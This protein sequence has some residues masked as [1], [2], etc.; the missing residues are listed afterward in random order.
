[1]KLLIIFMALPLLLPSTLVGMVWGICTVGF[2][3]GMTIVKEF[4]E[5][6]KSEMENER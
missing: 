2:V 6:V 3:G 5:S 1:M 4:L